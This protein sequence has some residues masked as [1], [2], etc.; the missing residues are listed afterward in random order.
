MTQL[1]NPAEKYPDEVF[2]FLEQ[3]L[4]L[5]HQDRIKASHALDHP[6][7]RPLL[8]A[9]SDMAF[10]NRIYRLT[11]RRSVRDMLL[12]K[13]PAGDSVDQQHATIAAE[14]DHNRGDENINYDDAFGNKVND[15]PDGKNNALPKN[16][17]VELLRRYEPASSQPDMPGDD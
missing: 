9:D 1:Y 5:H 3:T 17:Y 11:R 15:N 8:E 14:S 16:S 10:R 4:K 12:A 6:Y 7:L 13:F 2:D